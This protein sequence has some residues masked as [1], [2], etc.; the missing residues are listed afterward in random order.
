MFMHGLSR[1]ELK[2]KECQNKLLIS[3]VLKK[4]FK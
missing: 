2:K 3:A 4:F 1:A